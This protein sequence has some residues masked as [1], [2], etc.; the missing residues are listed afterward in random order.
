[1]EEKDYTEF[2]IRRLT[3]LLNK[4]Y[5]KLDA[6][7]KEKEKIQKKIDKKLAIK[8]EIDKQ[9][10]EKLIIQS[11]VHSLLRDFVRKNENIT[12]QTSYIVSKMGKNES[13]PLLDDRIIQFIYARI[14][15]EKYIEA[16]KMIFCLENFLKCKAYTF[17]TPQAF[18]RYEV[19]EYLEHKILTT[20]QENGIYLEFICLKEQDLSHLRA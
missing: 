6:Y 18:Y 16:L 13:I 19:W 8:K 1:M 11:F 14:E 15:S 5:E 10:Y 17:L 4:E 20:R 2:S 7:C 12:Y 3:T 9:L